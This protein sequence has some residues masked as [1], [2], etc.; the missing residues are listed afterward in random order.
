VRFTPAWKVIAGELA[1]G[2]SVTLKIPSGPQT[3]VITVNKDAVIRSGLE[4]AVFVVMEANVAGGTGIAEER[5]VTLGGAIGNRFVV[6]TG[7]RVGELT[8]IRGNEG[9]LEGNS[10]SF[11]P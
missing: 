5:A 9:L 10:L 11:T 4:T 8:V 7:L 2:Q 1:D 3:D 6:L